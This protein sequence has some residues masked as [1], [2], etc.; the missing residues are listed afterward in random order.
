MGPLTFIVSDKVVDHL[1]VVYQFRPHDK[2]L[3]CTACQETL[4][5]DGLVS[6]TIPSRRDQMSQ[7]PC[8]GHWWEGIHRQWS[9]FH[10]TAAIPLAL[11]PWLFQKRKS[12]VPSC[13]YLLKEFHIVG[14]NACHLQVFHDERCQG[15][16]SEPRERST[17]PFH[18]A[19]Y[20]EILAETWPRYL[21]PPR[22]YWARHGRA[23][24]PSAAT[25]RV[26]G[27]RSGPRASGTR[28]WLWR[29]SAPV[30][31][32]GPCQAPGGQASPAVLLEPVCVATGRLPRSLHN[33]S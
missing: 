4:T 12:A 5:K 25:A 13:H 26:E 29:H 32:T 3:V 30:Q 8:R 11:P 14:W 2:I 22:G 17:R 10:S 31:G 28:P 19:T 9:L 33:V 1:L 23:W 18:G 7:D 15:V 6:T 20:R 27:R 24:S 16:G 21:A